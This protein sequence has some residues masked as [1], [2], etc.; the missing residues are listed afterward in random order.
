MTTDPDSHAAAPAHHEWPYRRSAARRYAVAVVAIAVAFSIRY[1]IY[2]DLQNRLVFTFFVPAAMIAVWYGG[3]GPGILATV[4]GLL[5]GDYFFM[6]SRKAL[7]PLGN[8]E[9]LALGVYSVTT[10]LCVALCERLHSRIRN[11]ERALEHERHHH[12]EL[13]AEARGFADYLA[14]YYALATNHSYSYPSWPYRRPFVTRYGVAIGITVLAFVARYW[15][16]GTQDLRFPF[17]FF[18]PA[19]M[20]AVWYGGILPGLLATALGLMLGD[21]FFLSEHEA[22][23][24]VREY[25]RIQ[26][27]LFAVTTTLCVMLLE[28]LHERIRRLEHAFDHARHHHHSPHANAVAP[29]L[30]AITPPAC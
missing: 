6:L 26:I 23:G 25:E 12:G 14:H 10:L 17:L 7:W 3:V 13:P 20:V 30:P 28:N 15:L 16:F 9:S 29:H 5:L 27:G 19:A 18:V 21:Y 4:L 2:G 11:F 8:R 24:V 1:L 22:M